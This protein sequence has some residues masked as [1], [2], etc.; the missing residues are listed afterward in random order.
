MLNK[1]LKNINRTSQYN[2]DRTH[3]LRMDANERI[4]PFGKKIISN[5][6]EIID[7]NILQ[8]YPTTSQKLINLISRKEKLNNKYINLVPGSDSAIK[9]IFET[10]SGKNN[11]VVSIYPTYGMIDVYSKI[12]QLKL[13]KFYENKIEN[14]FLNSTYNKVAFLYIANPNQPSG[15]IIKKDLINKIIKKARSK[16]KYIIIDE[17]YID[18]SNQKSCSQMV[19]EYKNLIILK[20]FSKSTG[21]A[22]LRIGYMICNPNISKII[23]VIR[24][25][26]DISY[27]SL[28]V[29][30]YFLLN[31]KILK[32][33]L[34]EIKVCKK[35]VEQ[36]C[37]K[38]NLEFLNTQANF[39]HIF[40]KKNKV[41]KI[42]KFLRN[43][44]ILVKSKYSKGFK[45]LDNS[46]RVTYGSKQQMSYFFIQLD[47]VY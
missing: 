10:L 39:F 17:A 41:K 7:D 5:L 14:F 31:R 38:R 28:K 9:Y 30:E 32:N 29:A 15:K 40:L 22:G 27:F 6:R 35:F 1:H 45:V 19:K 23:N 20:T 4:K 13:E 34:K 2:V 8:S 24:P 47:K 12:Y 25:I 42:S 43:K 18:F 11:K 46:I 26:F 37:L 44:K 3:F 21:I 33:Y 36:E 16:N